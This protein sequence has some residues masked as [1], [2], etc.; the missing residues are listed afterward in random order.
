MLPPQT[1]A[2]I[3][4]LNARTARRARVAAERLAPF[5]GAGE[6]RA[7]LR[8]LRSA[9]DT[10]RGSARAAFLSNPELRQ[11]VHQAEEAVVFVAARGSDRELFERIA[12][13]PDLRRLLPAGRLDRGFRGR[14]RRLGRARIER[15]IRRLP[16]LVAGLT[17]PGDRF[18]PFLLDLDPDGED[19]RVRGEIHLRFPVPASLR[20]RPGARL[21]LVAGGI[22]IVQRGRGARWAPRARLAGSDIVLARRVRWTRRGLRPGPAI[23]GLAERL[24]QSLLLVREAWPEA[25]REILAHT[26]E[27]IPL[28]ESGV[29]SYSLPERPGTSYINVQGKSALELADDLLHETAHH[30]LHRLEEWTPLHR[31]DPEAVYYSPWRRA[32][33]P[34]HGI[35]HA[36]YTFAFRAELFQRLLAATAGRRLPRAWMRR[37][38]EWEIAALV[39]SLESLADAERRGLLTAAGSEVRRALVRHVRRL[40]SGSGPS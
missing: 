29:V 34:L 5:A 32:L 12:T 20:C 3:P 14:L 40:A 25:H 37:E 39:G 16:P 1:R 35:L 23:P 22:R 24:E 10:A 17:A 2:L 33:R 18:G 38:A 19:A 27:V 30:R 13:G 15:L 26:R 6:P 7:A 21:E 36:V 28:L 11:W 31:I 4:R 8:A 9:L